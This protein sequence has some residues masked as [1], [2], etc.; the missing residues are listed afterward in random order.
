MALSTRHRRCSPCPRFLTCRT[1]MALPPPP[2]LPGANVQ[3]GLLPGV[4]EAPSETGGLP[5]CPRPR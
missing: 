2:A 4:S 5:L 3:G 1:G